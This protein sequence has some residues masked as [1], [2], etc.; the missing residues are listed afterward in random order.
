MMRV[1]F[2]ALTA[3][4]YL[5]Y[6]REFKEIEP[7]KLEEEDSTFSKLG[8]AWKVVTPED[9]IRIEGLKECKGFMIK[10]T[11]SIW[12]EISEILQSLNKRSVIELAMKNM[13]SCRLESRH[14]YRTNGSASFVL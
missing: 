10:L 12:S 9:N 11:Q 1:F 2:H 6:A 13:L 4:D 3:R 14:W 5:D 7:I 8:M